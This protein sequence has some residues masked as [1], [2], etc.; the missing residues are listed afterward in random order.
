M[1]N[2]E[3][4]PRA[5]FDR[6]HCFN[7]NTRFET[8]GQ[9]RAGPSKRA[10]QSKAKTYPS[11]KGVSGGWCGVGGGERVKG[12]VVNAA[13]GGE[14]TEQKLCTVMTH[15]SCQARTNNP[16]ASRH[17][18]DPQN[19]KG[20]KSAFHGTGA[21]LAPRRAWSGS[22][23]DTPCDARSFEDIYYR[24]TRWVTSRKPVTPDRYDEHTNAHSTD[25]SDAVRPISLF[26]LVPKSQRP[27]RA[28]TRCACFVVKARTGTTRT[29]FC[30]LRS[31]L[32]RFG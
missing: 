32:S 19:Q 13:G 9:G 11:R 25:A 16:R 26:G 31:V 27:W 7:V 23:A 17:K 3:V 10:C 21:T 24:E 22:D 15:C 29:S 8:I 1:S 20:S 28:R 18:T 6:S 2:R 30:L 12:A 14:L 4:G 5:E